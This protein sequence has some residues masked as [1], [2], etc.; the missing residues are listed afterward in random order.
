MYRV[1]TTAGRDVTA[2]DL[3]SPTPLIGTV[4]EDYEVPLCQRCQNRLFFFFEG[5]I[6]EP[7]LI[8]TNVTVSC[9]GWRQLVVPG[10]P[11]I[12][13]PVFSYRVQYTTSESAS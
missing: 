3:L 12:I 8:Y 4:R 13:N 2:S 7:I 9:A 10:T 6:T 1:F 11:E 5:V